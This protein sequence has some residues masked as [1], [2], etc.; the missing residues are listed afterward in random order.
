MSVIAPP[1]PPPIEDPK[2]DPE[3]AGADPEALIEEA[4]R[5]ARRRRHR[6]AALALALALAGVGTYFGLSAGGAAPTASVGS[7]DPSLSQTPGPPTDGLEVWFVRGFGP[8]GGGPCCSVFPT[9]RTADE[10]GISPDLYDE[11]DWVK[12]DPRLLEALIAALI[13]AWIAGPTQSEAV[14]NWSSTMHPG[15]RLRGVSVEDGIVT[16]DIASKFD[17]TV[18]VPSDGEW[19]WHGGNPDEEVLRYWYPDG[20]F[21]YESG[22]G[23]VPLHR[24]SSLVFTVTQFPSVRGVQFK[25]DGRPVKIRTGDAWGLAAVVDRP[26]T[27]QDYEENNG[28]LFASAGAG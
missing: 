6:Y 18:P 16:I 25:L 4:R 26:V 12:P 28:P 14:V 24:L 9:R 8:D 11:I 22:P 2:L 7:P 5:R 23:L 15:T 20:E 17:P 13:A 1:D 3:S 27:R 10:L 19:V 21:E